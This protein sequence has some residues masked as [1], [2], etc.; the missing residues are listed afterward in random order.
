MQPHGYCKLRGSK[1][2][3]SPALLPTA[4]SSD[5]RQCPSGVRHHPC[6]PG[7]QDQDRECHTPH[8]HKVP[9]GGCCGLAPW[10]HATSQAALAPSALMLH[11]PSSVVTTFKIP[12]TFMLRPQDLPWHP[13][14]PPAFVGLVEWELLE[15]R[16]R[17]ISANHCLL[18]ASLP[19][20]PLSAN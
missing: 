17:P 2:H 5:S 6:A 8:H 16:A 14:A 19:V 4:H 15:A 7:E 10:H 20:C 18:P 9:G 11:V 13:A 12:M 1:L 3:L